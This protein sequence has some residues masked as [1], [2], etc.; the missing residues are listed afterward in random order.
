MGTTK[1]KLN[2]K[3]IKKIIKKNPNLFYLKEKDGLRIY[4][5]VNKNGNI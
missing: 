5:E 2:N 1:L 4:M 3:E